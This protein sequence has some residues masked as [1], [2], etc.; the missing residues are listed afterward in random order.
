MKKVKILTV[1]PTVSL[2]FSPFSL[3][4]ALPMPSTAPSERQVARPP[5]GQV[6]HWRW[7]PAAP[8]CSSLFF[9]FSCFLSPSL[10]SSREHPWPPLLPNSPASFQP[11]PR[12]SNPP[13]SSAPSSSP[14]SP[15]EAC[16]G[17][18]YSKDFVVPFPLRPPASSPN[19]PLPYRRASTTFSAFFLVSVASSLAPSLSPFSSSSAGHRAP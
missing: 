5:A 6:D 13:G 17:A 15:T 16:G 10:A 14:S 3:T 12:R 11:S 8:T 1:V 19:R 4:V 18:S 2:S 7:S 9:P